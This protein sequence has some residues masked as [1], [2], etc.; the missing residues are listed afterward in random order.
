MRNK[1]WLIQKLFSAAK[2]E[3]VPFL[4]CRHVTNKSFTGHK[5]GKVLIV[6]AAFFLMQGKNASVIQNK[7]FPPARSNRL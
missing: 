1:L 7:V 2:T 4:G 5:Q 6:I 3:M